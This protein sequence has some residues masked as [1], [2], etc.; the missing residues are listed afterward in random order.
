MLL[1]G[2]EW[3]AAL[4][5]DAAQKVNLEGMPM[6]SRGTGAGLDATRLM[7]RTV[8]TLRRIQGAVELV[9]ATECSS[10]SQLE[11]DARACRPWRSCFLHCCLF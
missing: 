4:V 3:P 1:V 6:V 9:A 10:V 11:F 5:N 7:R 8:F 2:E